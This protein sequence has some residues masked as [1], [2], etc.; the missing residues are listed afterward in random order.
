MAKKKRPGP[1]PGTRLKPP[2]Q[3]VTGGKRLGLYLLPHDH[4]RLTEAADR[5]RISIAAL[6][7]ELI[8]GGL[9]GW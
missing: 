3:C 4:A 9:A 7:R 6:A 1:K 2:E 8:A 5:R